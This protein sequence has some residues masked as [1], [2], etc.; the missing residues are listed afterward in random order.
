MGRYP[1]W[2]AYEVK[3]ELIK[4]NKAAARRRYYLSPWDE[5]KAKKQAKYTTEARRAEYQKYREQEL[6][7]SNARKAR[8]RAENA[9]AAA[10]QQ[11]P[12]D[13]ERHREPQSQ[14]AEEQEPEEHHPH[15]T[16]T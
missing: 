1:D 9:V 10:K 6:A 8:I 15:V 5:I 14:D 2:V 3:A 4:M 13:P 12:E 16:Q 7:R 11:E